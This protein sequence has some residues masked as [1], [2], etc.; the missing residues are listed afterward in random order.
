M[1]GLTCGTRDLWSSLR[2]VS[3]F[4][5]QVWIV[6]QPEIE[7]RP[8]ALRVQSLSHWTTR[9][10]LRLKTFFL[11][12]LA[13]SWHM[14]LSS[15]TRDW[16]VAPGT[17]SRVLTTR[18]PENSLGETIVHKN[19]KSEKRIFRPNSYS[20]ITL[21]VNLIIYSAFL[22]LTCRTPGSA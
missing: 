1:L 13:T 11:F 22:Y 15:L 17:G 6:H 14:V 5:W 12:F 9:E 7:H 8:P 20:M 16:T 21:V 4:S 19:L 10:I 3:S 2:H 18:L